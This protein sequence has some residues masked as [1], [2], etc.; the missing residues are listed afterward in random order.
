[1]E[2]LDEQSKLRKYIL[3]DVND[4]ARSAIEERLLTD[5]EYLEE[6]SMAEE[7]LIQDYADGNLDVK[8]RE[9]FE[10]CFLSSEENRQKVKF[11]RALRKYV[12]EAENSP[13]TEK[14]PNF[15]KSL[16]AFFSAPVPIAFTFLII[17]GIGGFFI[18]KNYS[19][20]SEVLVALN[21]AY[22]TERPIESRIS[23]FNY[24]PLK[25]TRG[26]DD[27][28]DKTALY[29][30]RYAAAKAI[31]ENQSA[32]NYHMLGR[33][34]LTDKEFD[35]AIEQFEKA[36]KIEP[37][38]AKT[39]ND[40]GVALMEKAKLQ[41]E[42]NLENFAKANE[43][44][45]KAIELDKSLLAAYF[46]QA[47]CIQALNLPNQ[48]KEA[49]QKYLQLD[50][51][52]QWA[53]EAKKNLQEIEV[54]Q[55]IG[56]TKEE[57]LRDF[58]EAKQTGNH[59]KAWQ[60]LSRN[61]EMITGK[62]IPQQLAFLFVD[63]K[64]ASDEAKAK[65]F[66]EALVYVGKLEEEKSGD[67]YW[68]NLAGFYSA[69]SNEK[70]LLLKQAHESVK[71]G[72]ELRSIQEYEKSFD[73][74]LSAKKT[75][76][77]LG[78]IVEEKLC[79][80]WVAY[81]L[82]Q[83][84]RLL[85]SNI[86]FENLATIGK[87]NQYKWLSTQALIR[88]AYAKGS[89]NDHSK[90]IEYSKSALDYIKDTNDIYNQNR[91]LTIIANKYKDLGQYETSLNFS[92]RSLKIGQLPEASLSQRWLDYESI[93]G[94]FQELKLYNTSLSFQKEALKIAQ[95]VKDR[96]NEQVSN[97]YLA[98]I[99]ILQK[100]YAEAEDFIKDSIRIAES[101][102]DEAVKQ[103]TLAHTALQYGNLKRLQEKYEEAINSL[104]E[105]GNFYDKSEFQLGRYNVHKEKLLSL[106]QG[107]SDYEIRSELQIILDIFRVHRKKILE[108]QSR[109]SFFENKQT[110]YDIAVDYEFS[111]GNY[112]EAF[113]YSEESRSRSLLDLQHSIVK[114]STKEKQFEINL[115]PNV[116]EPLKLS[117]IQAEIPEKVQIIEYIVLED[118]VLIW[119]I[120]SNSLDIALSE[121]SSQILQEK[122][123]AYLNLVSNNIAPNEQRILSAELYQLLIKPIKEKLDA[124][125]EIFLIPDKILFRLPFATLL[126]E[127]YFIEE[128]SFSYAP[129]A[130]V[131][132][133]CSRIAKKIETKT[134][135]TLLSIG[136]PT[137]SN[138]VF[139]NLQALP[140]AKEE[141]IEITRFYKEFQIFTEK[142]ATKE[143]VKNNLPKSDIVHFA[144]HY[145]VD[146]FSPLLSSLVLAGNQKEDSSLANYEIIGEKFSHIR[147]IVLSA[148]QTG[149]EKYYSGE[150][151][152][153]ASRTFLA[154]GVPLVVSSQW[155]VDSDATAKLMIDFHNYRKTKELSTSEALRQSQ[156]DMLKSEKYQQPHYW[157]AFM[158]L[159]GYSKF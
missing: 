87:T 50:S 77:A 147:L 10:N 29:L 137:F 96:H 104:N 26:E 17:A 54:K 134:S 60:T 52:S 151:M 128:Y 132:I 45:A 144:G 47:L 23:D 72:Y 158:T 148:C 138:K 15:F 122:V 110:I 75:F 106:L 130:N 116:F 133:T 57:V 1:L 89:E 69:V 18:W 157:A 34:F 135:E 3:N 38:R 76:L 79:D 4:E 82:F 120:T 9:K 154:T 124:S 62:L 73:K 100:R 43:E 64:S 39:H 115:P 156:L 11:A 78:N 53:E 41:T 97:V 146:E 42:G 141:A 152:I 70:F 24:A 74:F 80:Y 25:N 101:F 14:K 27:K 155:G 13:K 143:N 105:A 28:S 153:S 102:P 63:A 48:A 68:K 123:L 31:E 32:E 56:K 30:A 99:S 35:K 5:D 114:V 126:S 37:N 49:W 92:E 6:V 61:R 12:N 117:E 94:A 51:T 91:A 20:D 127:K 95:T 83:Q 84:N 107:K 66:L 8:E 98:R 142:D 59:E 150:G 159:G 44:F 67:L 109:N 33:V 125:K 118:K 65:E 145:V 149:I 140:S 19:K 119:L 86:I 2:Q 93:T 55:P 40:L 7:N 112:A 131:F 58:L 16:K 111:K 103:K 46:N 36:V 136:N 129:S 22:K 85:D 113:D 88:L 90:A 21:K 81:N 108:E 121:V 71:T 139:E